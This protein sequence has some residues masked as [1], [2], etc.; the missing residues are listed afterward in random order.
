MTDIL[1]PHYFLPWS[2]E[3]QLE[4]LPIQ[5]TPDLFPSN[6]LIISGVSATENILGVHGISGSPS[7][8]LKGQE[9][10]EIMVASRVRERSFI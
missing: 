8:P 6:F 4:V 3:G 2:V 10:I 5:N 1:C 7:D 9:I